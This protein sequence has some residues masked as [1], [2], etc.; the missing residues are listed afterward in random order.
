M[1]ASAR[2]DELERRPSRAST[3]PRMHTPTHLSY[4]A[5]ASA[6]SFYHAISHTPTSKLPQ[7]SL[8]CAHARTQGQLPTASPHTSVGRRCD[9]H[10]RTIVR[11]TVG[12][13]ARA[14]LRNKA[15]ACNPPPIF[16]RGKLRGLV[17]D[18]S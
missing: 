16:C 12:T 11:L 3:G 13:P 18:P 14:T 17:G 9:V 10:A 4:G 15:P 8:T 2:H 1:I 7:N 6:C 5:E